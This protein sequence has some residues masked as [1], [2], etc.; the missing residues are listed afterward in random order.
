MGLSLL[1]KAL[2]LEIVDKKDSHDFTQKLDFNLFSNYFL[3]P[4]FQKP[5]II[6]HKLGNS[7]TIYK[8]YE[9]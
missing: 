7:M 9:R 4:A 5:K 2:K 6:P 8:K 3:K 1:G